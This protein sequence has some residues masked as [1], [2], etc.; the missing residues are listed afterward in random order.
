MPSI[1]ASTLSTLVGNAA[2]AAIDA[3]AILDQAIDC[4]NLEGNLELSNMQGTA[5]SK[6][7]G[8]TSKERGAILYVARAIYSSFYQNA[9]TSTSIS[10]MSITITDVLSNPVVAETVQRMARKLHE[11]DWSAAII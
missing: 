7:V 11:A 8:A 6:T 3:E 10:G 9:S 2:L 4:L 5:G 1:T